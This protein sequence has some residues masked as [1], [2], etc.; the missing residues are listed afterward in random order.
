MARPRHAI[1][2]PYD[3][4]FAQIMTFL[5]PIFFIFFIVLYVCLSCAIGVGICYVPHCIRMTYC[6][7]DLPL[8]FIMQHSNTGKW[9][10]DYTGPGL[11]IDWHEHWTRRGAVEC[12]IS[13]YR[14]LRKQ[15]QAQPIWTIEAGG[16]E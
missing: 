13:N 15:E 2:R 8:G 4:G 14:K 7:D 16:H 1:S 12:A 9:R 11:I 5:K 3:K 6:G 10:F